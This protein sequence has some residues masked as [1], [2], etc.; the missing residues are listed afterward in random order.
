MDT[1]FALAS[2]AGRAGIAVY[3]LSGP[4]A[5]AAL[6]ALSG[7]AL[8]P[9]RHAT[10]VRL[11]DGEGEGIDAGLVLWFPGPASFTGDDVVELHLHGGRAVAAALGQALVGL[12]LRPAEPGEF[13]KRAVLAG[14]LDFTRAEAMADLIEAE[15][16]AQRR[17]A[18][19]QMGGA[20]EALVEG[21]RAGLVRALALVEAVID[22]SDE[23]VGE[24]EL[25]RAAAQIAALKF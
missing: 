2:G 10:R 21:W 15:T 25:E 20:L 1:I 13:S 4:Q 5:G 22:F 24:V 12:G 7:R 19:R 23:G 9:P 16:A 18:L 8:P 6:V 14:K 3:R 11:R 17:Q